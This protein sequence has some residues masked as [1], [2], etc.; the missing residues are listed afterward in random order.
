MFIKRWYV[1]SCIF[2][3]LTL[4]I[5]V[6]NA[7]SFVSMI[8][9]VF[10]IAFMKSIKVIKEIIILKPFT[11]P[12]NFHTVVVLESRV[13]NTRLSLICFLHFSWHGDRHWWVWRSC[14]T[15]SINFFSRLIIVSD[16]MTYC[17]YIRRCRCKQSDILIVKRLRDKLTL[18]FWNS[19]VY[20]SNVWIYKKLITILTLSTLQSCSNEHRFWVD[21]NIFECS[22]SWSS[23]RMYEFK[24]Q[25]L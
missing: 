3:F 17:Y 14:S 23:A 12:H 19:V 21:R 15:H 11:L 6:I 18:K 2:F 9:L 22:D 13:D 5:I 10:F 1:V 25:G 20:R 16:R 8:F 4:N 7:I 24:S